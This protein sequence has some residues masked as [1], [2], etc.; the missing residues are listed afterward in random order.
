MRND[1]SSLLIPHSSF[2]VGIYPMRYL[3]SGVKLASW[4]G[5]ETVDAAMLDD[6]EASL[7]EILATLLDPEEPFI[8]K[9]TTE[10]CRYC[11]ATAFC[12]AKK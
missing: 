5:I 7:G 10:A 4:D 6:F 11:P 2:N 8:P 12:P 9:P 1:N 3:Q